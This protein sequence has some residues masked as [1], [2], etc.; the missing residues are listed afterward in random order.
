MVIDSDDGA[1]VARRHRWSRRDTRLVK[2][3]GDLQT[4][5]ELSAQR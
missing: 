3:C 1:P 4:S 2:R 5:R